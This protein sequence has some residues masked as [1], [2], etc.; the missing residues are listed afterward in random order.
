MAAGFA[1]LAYATGM[2]WLT[3]SILL[4]GA[5]GGAINGATTAVVSDTSDPEERGAR[6]SLLSV[7]FGV[8]ALGMPIL[9][10]ALKHVFAY[11]TVVFAVS[12]LAFL[13]GLTYLFIRF[14]EPKQA[15]GFPISKVPGLIKDPLL[16][17]IGGFLFFQSAFEAIINNWTTTYLGVRVAANERQALMGLSIY[18][19]GMTLMRLATGSVLRK[20]SPK[21]ILHVSLGMIIA[22]LLI[23]QFAPSLAVSV[24]GLFVLGLGLAGG[25]PIMFGFVGGRFTELSGTAFSLVIVAA[26]I[27]NMLIN[28]LMGAIAQSAGVVYLTWVAAAEWVAMALLVWAIGRRLEKTV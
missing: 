17:L 10:G 8:G 13:T 27:G 20:V 11:E 6:L 5:G 15:Q 4:I 7:S 12:G 9:L 1:G 28:Y 16:L 14:P 25:F 22:G 19:L 2:S 26:L 3:I 24:S 23:M 21:V 18:V